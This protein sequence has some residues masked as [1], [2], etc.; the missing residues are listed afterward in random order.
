MQLRESECSDVG[1]RGIAVYSDNLRR[2]RRAERRPWA[3]ERKDEQ[4]YPGAGPEFVATR[5]PV[6]KLH[7]QPKVPVK[8]GAEPSLQMDKHG[9]DVVV[10]SSCH[11]VMRRKGSKFSLIFRRS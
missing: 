3:S 2:K 7:D 4:R 10:E 1:G 8:S 5:V 9:G 11:C 6:E